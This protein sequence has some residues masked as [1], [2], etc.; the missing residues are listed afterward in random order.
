MN[1]RLFLSPIILAII[2]FISGCGIAQTESLNPSEKPTL[3]STE[4]ASPTVTMIPSPT[5]TLQIPVSQGTPAPSTG[6]GITS[7]NASQLTEIARW[8]KGTLKAITYSPDGKQILAGTSV[9]MYVFDAETWDELPYLP[10]NSP[11][12]DN[13]VFSSNGKLIGTASF[14]EIMIWNVSDGSEVFTSEGSCFAFSPNSE[15][16]ATCSKDIRLWN[17]ADGT[18]LNTFTGHSLDVGGIVFAPDGKSIFS[19]SNVTLFQTQIP[20]GELLQSYSAA[21]NG[22]GIQDL[23]VSPDGQTLAISIDGTIQLYDVTAKKQLTTLKN[24]VFGPN[25]TPGP[26]VAFSA[27]GQLLATTI[28]NGSV[29]IWKVSDGTQLLRLG[30][31]E[32]DKSIENL[33]A[34]GIGLFISQGGP[35]AFS[36]DGKTLL[37]VEGDLIRLWNVTDGSLRDE[38]RLYSTPNYGLTLSSDEQVL[39]SVGGGQVLHLMQFPSGVVLDSQFSSTAENAVFLPDGK[40]ITNAGGNIN[41]VSVQGGNDPKI[42][43]ANQATRRIAVSPDGKLLALETHSS[44]IADLTILNLEDEKEFLKVNTGANSI[45]DIE[46]SSDGQYVAISVQNPGMFGSDSSGSTRVYRVSDGELVRKQGAGASSY[47]PGAHLAYSPDGQYLATT[48]DKL[49]YVWKMPQGEM[50][51][52]NDKHTSFINSIAFSSDGTFIVTG[53]QDGS[54]WIWDSTNGELIATIAAHTGKVNDLL[55]T[56]DNSMLISSSDDGTI[57]IWGLKP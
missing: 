2:L 44:A 39:A 18:L 9:G 50:V 35:V 14:S 30:A 12:W 38:K 34:T 54:I 52:T 42:L 56:S 45:S 32:V 51:F 26:N 21:P 16:L 55:F 23:S 27:D 41:L 28:G 48:D 40:M 25:I 37:Q 47:F 20:D 1:I 29:G 3:E 57:R 19:Y 10:V 46:F 43:A 8:G 11:V 31:E 36:A 24:S 5:A 13:L 33:M 49:L 17:L 7:Q 53:T 6:A 15:I 4:I 22:Q